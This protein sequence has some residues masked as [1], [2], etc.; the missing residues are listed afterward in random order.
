MVVEPDQRNG[1]RAPDDAGISGA[2]LD[3]FATAVAR[4]GEQATLAGALQTIVD[5]IAG[6]THADVALA[7]VLDEVGECLATGAVSARSPAVAAELAGSRV[8]AS[9]VALAEI[10]AVDELPEGTRRAAALLG[11]PAVLQIPVHAHGRATATLELMRLQGGFTAGDR[12]L[13]R[14]AAAHVALAVRSFPAER[15]AAPPTAAA[16]QLAGEALAAGS[17]GTRTAIEV[18]RLAAETTGAGSALL[19][20]ADEDGRPALTAWHGSDGNAAAAPLAEAAA[21]AVSGRGGPSV[22]AE[23]VLSGRPVHVETVSLGRP[24]LGALQLVF[25]PGARPV[26]GDGPALAAFGA[27]AAYALRTSASTRRMSAELERARAL[28]TVIAQAIAQLSLAHTLETA[29]DRVAELLGADRVAIYLR[30]AKELRE[31][32]ARELEGPHLLVGEVLLELAL[33][34]FRARGFVLV[35]DA[36]TDLRLTRVHDA[37]EQSGIEAALAV[38]LVAREEVIGLIAVY[39][40]R[41]RSVTEDEAALVRALAVQLAVAVENARLHEEAKRLGTELEQA[42][43]SERVAAR[44]LGTL[45]EISRSFAQ[46]LSL[47]TTLEAVARTT[48]DSFDLDAAV[49]RMPDGRRESLVTRAIHV[50]DPRLDTVVRTIM[51]RSQPMSAPPVQR[52]LETAEPLVLDP[53]RARELDTSHSLLAPFLEK[54]STA[55]I[56]PIATS[57]EV[58][59]TLTLLSLDPARPITPE[60]VERA[61]TIAGQAALAIDNAR[62]YQ[63]QKD[64]ADTMQR[65]L[66][67]RRRPRLEG[68]ELGDVYESS[69]RVD[70]GGDVYDYL[71]LPDGRLAVVLGDVTGH[72]IEATADMAMTKFVFRSLVREHPHAGEF[73]TFANEVVL[74]EVPVGKFVTMVCLTIDPRDGEVACA[75]AGH[76]PP[77]LLRGDGVVVS[78]GEGGL[79]LGI[80]TGQTYPEVRETLAGDDSIVLYTDGLIEARREGELYGVERLDRL[81]AE[82]AGLSAQDLAHAV[83]EDCRRFAGG[84]LSDDCA[85]VVIKRQAPR[86]QPA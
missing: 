5:A 7:R 75:S 29:V 12:A 79:P 76:P 1:Q 61:M 57:A 20:L 30:D 19:W 16:L 59:A 2:A 22:G 67:P 41:R 70:V 82:K 39:P 53:Q 35:E 64:F 32:A 38:A 3:A 56:I 11:A 63:Q 68:L 23:L 83:V 14:L 37:V 31:A 81:L 60:T 86:P 10:D 6:P 77:R 25:E 4:L 72:G 65:S 55:G 48:V 21:Q 45:Y 50:A 74:G 17:D 40:P 33:G 52:L 9:A 80:E 27:R 71:T 13:A 51:T 69:A 42:L 15:T 49:I 24:A 28:L 66:L 47:E 78:L 54:G 43:G 73:L 36:G 84:E 62:L 85:V 34:P 58:L 46:S 8:P 44:Q 26:P 18:A